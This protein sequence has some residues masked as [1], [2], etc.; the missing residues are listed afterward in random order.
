MLRTIPILLIAVAVFIASS[1]DAVL[2]FL[3]TGLVKKEYL[4][5]PKCE[6][7]GEQ[8]QKENKESERELDE[9]FKYFSESMRFMASANSACIRQG[10]WPSTQCYKSSHN[11]S[12][13]T[14]PPEY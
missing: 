7:S 11:I 13:P 4:K 10:L 5:N 12:T 2:Y 14:P 3:D 8:E 9:R 6:E 1:D